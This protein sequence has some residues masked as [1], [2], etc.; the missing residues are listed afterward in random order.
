MSEDA[1]DEVEQTEASVE[2]TRDCRSGSTCAWSKVG[3]RERVSSRRWW[4]RALREAAERAETLRLVLFRLF[5][6][7]S[8]ECSP[9]P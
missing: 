6:S 1:R 8:C 4:Q 9:E 3:M 5:C 2:L 7:R